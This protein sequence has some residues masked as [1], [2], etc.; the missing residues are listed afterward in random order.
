MIICVCFPIAD[1]QIGIEEIVMLQFS[2][3]SRPD[4]RPFSDKAIL[5][6]IVACGQ[7][8]TVHGGL[9]SVII[10]E[11]KAVAVGFT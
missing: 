9:A 5:T 10:A 3:D 7:E 11:F 6:I 4:I 8:G 2:C 1:F